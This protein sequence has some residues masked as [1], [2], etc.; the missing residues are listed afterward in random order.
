MPAPLIAPEW[1]DRPL[2][3]D[4]GR[5]SSRS[6][7]RSRGSDADWDDREPGWGRRSRGVEEATASV[8]VKVRTF[9]VFQWF[10]DGVRAVLWLCAVAK[11]A[12]AFTHGW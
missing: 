4:W 2:D 6:R 9:T 7:G 1:G 5:D 8:F 10:K 3:D 12:A 11:A